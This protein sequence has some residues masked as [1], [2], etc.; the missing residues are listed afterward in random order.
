MSA[1]DLTLYFRIDC[2]VITQKHKVMCSLRQKKETCRCF[3]QKTGV[4]VLL[5][6]SGGYWHCQGTVA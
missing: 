6:L 3:G 2:K 1:E 4:G 5:F